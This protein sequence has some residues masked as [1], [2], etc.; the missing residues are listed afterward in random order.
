MGSGVDV[1]VGVAEGVWVGESIVVGVGGKNLAVCVAIVVSVGVGVIPA[2]KMLA[3]VDSKA[4]CSSAREQ[5][6]VN[7]E[8]ARI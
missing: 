1:G 3:G 5:L 6:T 7:S 4:G 8:I 2:S